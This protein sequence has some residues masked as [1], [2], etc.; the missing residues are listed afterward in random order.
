[1]STSSCSTISRPASSRSSSRDASRGSCSSGRSTGSASGSRS[2]RRSRKGDV[3]LID[4]AYAHRP[5]RARLLDRHRPP[6]AGD[7]RPR[8]ARSASATP[9]CGSS[10][11]RRTREQVQRLVDRHGPNLF[12]HSVE[13]RLLC[14]NVRKVQPLTAAPRRA[15]RVGHRPPPRPVGVALGHP[16]GRD[17][18]R[19]RRDREAQPARR[20]DRGRGL[21]L[22]PR[23]RRARTTRSTRRATRRS[24]AR[25]AR[26][27]IAPGEPTRAGRWWWESNAPKECG[28]HCA[29]ETGGFEHE[30]HAILGER[31][32]R[33]APWRSRARSARS[34]SPRSHAVSRSRA[35]RE[36]PRAARGRSSRDVET[37]GVGDDEPPSVDRLV[38]SRC[39]PVGSARSTAPAASR[40]APALPQAA[41]RR[42]L[43][44]SAARDVSEALPALQGR[45]LEDVS[46]TAV[47]PGAFSLVVDGRRRPAEGSP[48]PPGRAP[49]ERRGLSVPDDSATTWRASTSRAQRARRRRRPRSRSRRSTGCSTA[50]RGVTVV[51]PQIAPE[52]RAARCRACAGAPTP[53]TT[54]TGASS[55]SPRPR[56]PPSTGGSSP[57]PRR[58]ALLCNVVD[59][60]GA[61]Q[62]HPPRPVHRVGPI[63]IAVST[64]GASPALAQRLRDDIAGRRRPR[65]R[66]ARAPAPRPAPL[67]EEGVSDLR[68]ARATYF[69]QL[70]EAELAMTRHDLVGAGPGDPGSSQSAGSSASAPATPSSTTGSSPR[71]SS[72]R[73]PPTPSA[74]AAT[75]LGQ[76]QVDRLLVELGAGLDVV[77]LKGGDPF[78]FGRGSEEMLELAEAGIECEVVPGVSSIAAVPGGRLDPA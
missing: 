41:G 58:A 8:R 49:R 27:P 5:R 13:V 54:S 67:G 72:T 17:R 74:S 31:R 6:A 57:T 73:H 48:R 63:A 15:R 12:Y 42:E 3:A 62:L 56:R 4:M 33:D 20:V 38:S 78:V 46:L 43:A 18:P 26:A 39:S 22:P 19:P 69:Q 70:V 55:S 66:G 59:V 53:P 50:G 45:T 37:G 77:R 29:I 71:S 64:G 16:Q 10:S 32:T 11:S 40:R 30:L 14:C 44:Q 25:R 68:G 36:L 23:E 76:E 65:A 21:G 28:M 9:A 2:R 47:G 7:L 52:L 24:A 51:A 60:P 34:R 1:M 75:A 35:G 61:L